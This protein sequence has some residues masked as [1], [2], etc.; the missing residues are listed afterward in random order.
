MLKQDIHREAQVR[1][2]TT[3]SPPKNAEAHLLLELSPYPLASRE[4]QHHRP[5]EVFQPFSRLKGPQ[6]VGG[7][8]AV[9]TEGEEKGYRRLLFSVEEKTGMLA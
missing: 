7:T 2:T 8:V 9:H 5:V 4:F 6:L 1:T 3:C